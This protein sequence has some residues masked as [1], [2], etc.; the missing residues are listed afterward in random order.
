MTAPARTYRFWPLSF[1]PSP[2]PVRLY[3]VR[4]Q[5]VFTGLLVDYTD[6]DGKEVEVGRFPNPDLT[7]GGELK[8]A[9]DAR[10][11]AARHC[12]ASGRALVLDGDAGILAKV[13]AAHRAD[14]IRQMSAG[15]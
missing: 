1:T 5:S 15:G 6:E 12:I 9:L 11:A 3:G 4:P 8:S 13:K 7:P 10:Q 2:G 14:Y